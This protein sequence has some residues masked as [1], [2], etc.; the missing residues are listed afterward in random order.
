MFSIIGQKFITRISVIIVSALSLGMLSAIPSQ[1]VIGASTVSITASN[2]TAVRND[3]ANVAGLS[4]TTNAGTV[5]VSFQHTS[6]SDSVVISV[7]K[8]SAPSTTIP[9]LLFAFKDT[10]TSTAVDSF[11]LRQN[12]TLGNGSDSISAEGVQVN[13]IG[14]AHV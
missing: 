11:T 8:K 12:F 10:S 2:G 14:R 1:A 3:N 9:T 13:K 7:V 5:T 6:A 4:D